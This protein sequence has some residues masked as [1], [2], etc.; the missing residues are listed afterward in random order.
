M[1]VRQSIHSAHAKTLDTQG[2]RNEFLVEKVFVADEY[3]MVYS[4]ID[5]I[6]VG[7]I[8]PVTKTVSVGGEVGKQLGV[9]YF[10]ERRE[11]GV[12]NI[13]HACTITVDGQCYEI[14][15]R[16]AL[17]VGKGP[18]KKLSLPVLI[19]ALRRSCYYNCAPAH[20]T[21][22]AKKVTPDEVSPVTL[23]DNLTSNRRTINNTFVPDVLETC[24]LSMGLTE[25]APGN[26]WNT[27][28]C[29]THERRMEV[30]FYFNMDE[31]ACVFHMMG[32][33][34]ETRHIVIH[35]EQAVISPSW[36]IHSGVGTKAYTFIWG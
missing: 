32:Q 5:R 29:H 27:M 21:Y 24:Q 36:S 26:L 18:K 33:P 13:G 6:I 20:T 3:T 16:D 9:S 23:G 8:M 31:D 7:G 12:I 35:N 19:P 25:L 22:P 15:H 17:Y 28:P 14:G 34:Q 11:L 30:Y 1:D 4:H 10:L 2:L